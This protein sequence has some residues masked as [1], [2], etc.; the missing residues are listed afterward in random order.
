MS[1]LVQRSFS[2]GELAPALYARVDTTKYASGLRTCKNMLVMRHGGAQNRSGT[3]FICE[4]KDS[5]KTVRLIEFV[6]NSSQTYVLEF[7][8]QYMRVIKDGVQQ[9][10]SS[11]NITGITKANPAVLTYSGSD[12]Y[13]NGDEVY[14]ESVVGMTEVNGRWFKVANVDAG[15]NTFELNYKDGTAVDSSAFTTY[16]SGGT[17]AEV[18][19]ITTP[20]VEADLPALQFVQSADVVTIVHPTYAPRELSRTADT[21]WTLATITFDP[22]ITGPTNISCSGGGAGSR[23]ARYLVT[24]VNSLTGEESL[25]GTAALTGS[26][27]GITQASPG[28]VTSTAHGL[29]TGDVI[30]FASIGGMTELNGNS[31]LVVKIDADTFSL[32]EFNGTA[33]DTTGYTAYTSGGTWSQYC[34]FK[35]NHTTLSITNFITVVWD[36]V[37]DATEYVIY[38][39]PNASAGVFTNVF[40]YL[41]LSKATSFNDTG[42]DP[43]A[44]DNPPE[45]STVFEA[46]NDYPS[47]VTYIQQRRAFANTNNDTEKVWLSRT[48]NFKNFTTRSASQDDDSVSFV[49]AGRQVNAVKHMIDIGQ[50]VIFTTGGE[51][52]IQGDAANIITPTDVNPK[53]YSYNGSS[54][55]RPLVIGGNAVYVQARGSVVRDLS[56]DYTVEGY[57]GN[58]LTI[59]SAHLFD[60]YTLVDW[61]YQQIPHSIVWVVRSDG[62]LLGLTYV[63]EHEMMAWHKHEFDGGTVENVCCVP[64]GN[65]DATYVVVVR[66]I[67]GATKRYIERMS[68]RQVSES[69]IKD[70][71]FMDSALTYDGRHT[72]NT[73]MTISG[74]TNWTY[75][76][77]LTLTASAGTFTSAYVGNEIHMT[78]SDGTLIRFTIDAYTSSTVVTGRPNKTVPAAMRSTAISTWAYAV[79][80]VTGLWHIE[81]KDVSV[82]GDGFVVASPNNDSYDTVTITDGVAVL[83]K[84]YAVIHVGLPYI[85]DIE[86]LDI[87]TPQGETMADKKKFIS[88]VSLFTEKSRGIWVGGKPPTNDDTDPLEDLYELKIRDDEDYDSPVALQTGVVDINIKAEWG[89]NGRV[90]IRQVDPVPLA[91]LAVVPAG[92]LPMRG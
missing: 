2:G 20:Y 38:K 13:A 56:F 88:K 71:I 23:D 41:G 24:A 52:A 73:T 35:T 64:E 30:T 36:E 9:N 4:V 59:F 45:E 11:Q 69:T 49:L 83:D 14:I 26:I 92:L 7:G 89:S 78:G 33:I 19:Q 28:V 15:A 85:S 65:E 27:T 61:S 50:L 62:V 42:A 46:S 21:S 74:G 58:D 76:E 77:S 1:T 80:T 81:G 17:V 53:Q 22:E 48:G 82:F 29:V 70:A 10:L 66:T 40:G 79:D 68:T 12:T 8:D 44:A 43:D 75:D 16:S 60:E 31:Y 34:A 84:C 67:D 51:W 90:F 25:V 86:T 3:E 6:Y 63:R 55:L 87:D 18:Y 91:V 54:D 39:E 72:G 47:A 57:R 32:K 5:S 37:A